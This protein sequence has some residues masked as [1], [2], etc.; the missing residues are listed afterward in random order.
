MAGYPMTCLHF[1][2]IRHYFPAN[3]SCLAAARVKGTAGWRAYRAWY[4]S[5]DDFCLYVLRGKEI[6]GILLKS[7]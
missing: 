5:L 3:V 1:P 2:K 4:V 6:L 7:A